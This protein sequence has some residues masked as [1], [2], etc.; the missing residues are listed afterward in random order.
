MIYPEPEKGG[1][2]KK[3]AATTSAKI[4]GSSMD[5]IDDARAVVPYPDLSKAV[6]D[7]SLSLSDAICSRGAG[8]HAWYG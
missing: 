7:G 5:L 4:G 6:L 1:R 8:L 3:S 2:G